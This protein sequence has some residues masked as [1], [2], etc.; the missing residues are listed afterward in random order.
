MI[1]LVKMRNICARRYVALLILSLM[2]LSQGIISVR[3]ADGG[4]DEIL[5]QTEIVVSYTSYEWWLLRWSD[6]SPQCQIYI[7]HEGW[8]TQNEVYYSCGSKVYLEWV[9]TPSCSTLTESNT[10]T[11]GCI[12]LYLHEVSSTPS[13]KTILVDLPKPQV[14]LT[15]GN[16]TQTA[17]DNRCTSLP[18]LILNGEEP[19]PN[20]QI[21]AIHVNVQGID[22]G[23]PGSSCEVP[24]QPTTMSGASVE[25]W[26]D[27]S[28]GDASDHFTALV[29]VVD[30]GVSSTAST[31]AWYVDVLSSQWRGKQ[32]S[33]CAQL[34][35]S[36]PPLGGVP[37]WLSTPDSTSVLAS[38]VSYNYLAGRLISQGIVDA[39]SCPSN[40]LLPNGY[41]DACGLEKALPLVQEWQNRFDAKIIEVAQQTSVPAQLMKN[42]FAQ[43]SQFWP[44]AFKDPKEFGLGQITDS[45]A[46]ALLM[47]DASFY[48]Q[49]CPLILD[50]SNCQRGY[51]Y[52]SKE[53]QAIIRG[54]LA[55]QAKSDCPT[56]LT[57]IDLSS[58]DFSINLFANTLLANCSQVSRIIY[59]ATNRSPGSV[60]DYENLW[61]FTV[62]NYHVGPGCLSYAIYGAWTRHDTM[63]WE[64]VSTYLTPACQSVIP[65]VDKVTR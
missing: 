37:T 1:F 56:C 48:E 60:T 18:T 15:L 55:L 30:T 33:T 8:P 32:I 54:A 19:L 51:V 53:N 31:G 49:F 61:R 3:A 43:E 11:S 36:F 23:C 34:W 46:E 57:G 25:F 10:D 64:H 27:S 22:Y 39:Q 47:W 13:E 38:Q 9:N 59:N 6:N 5:R 28:F 2:I 16:C 12:G 50:S 29:R 17:T 21:T 41:S 7:D 14:Y 35:D 58:V 44:G 63:D 20:E 65:Y 40:G 4:P 45:G 62:A 42:L 24:L 26:A 52:L